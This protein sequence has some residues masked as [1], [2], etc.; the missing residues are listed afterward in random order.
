MRILVAG[1]EGMLA[2]EVIDA[3]RRRGHEVTPLGRGDLDIADPRSIDDAV[4]GNAPEAVINC[5]AWSDVD[6]AE[7]DERG[8]MKVNDE[9][10]ALLAAAA[11]RVGAKVVYPS[12]DYVFDGMKVTPYVESDLPAPISAYGRSKLG[13]ETS[14]AVANP[15][16]FIVRSSWL[17]GPAGKNFVA[18][19]LQIGREQP[20]VL[21]V[22]D[23]IGCPTSC[24]DLG[25]AL[26]G[27]AEGEDYGI[28]H[29]AGTGSCTWFE[30]AQEIFD[31]AG[32]ETRVMSTTSDMMAR[33]APRP[34]YSVLVS[35][36]PRPVVLPEW[37]KSLRRYLAD[38][39]LE[40]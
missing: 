30:F 24:V 2:H 18:T 34:A 36:R 16:H 26:V 21:V 27:L 33:R 37:R 1:G 14:V 19:M 12:S 5:A 7:D 22:S 20:E 4:G 31:Q 29:I 15:R 25:M 35:E 17:Y 9:G 10:A 11:E 38:L 39:E 13:G 28:H 8:A 3:A 23:Q 40:S 6:G 32:Y